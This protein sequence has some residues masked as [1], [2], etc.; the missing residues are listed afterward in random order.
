MVPYTNTESTWGF[1]CPESSHWSSIYISL[2]MSD[3]SSS[4]IIFGPPQARRDTVRIRTVQTFFR[5]IC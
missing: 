4:G 2:K 3:I 1:G 5:V